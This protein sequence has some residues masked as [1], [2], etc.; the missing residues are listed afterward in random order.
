MDNSSEP[1]KI[2]LWG[3]LHDGELREIKTDAAN[4]TADLHV[5]VP[6]LSEF[7]G[8]PDD[9]GIRFHF[10]QVTELRVN[11]WV[12]DPARGN[13]DIRSRRW[14]RGEWKAL[15]QAIPP[16]ALDVLEASFSRLDGVG[17]RLEVAGYEL[18]ADGSS[19]DI[20]LEAILQGAGVT[21][22][23]P[24]GPSDLDRLLQIGD[25]YW[26]NVGKKRKR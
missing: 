2:S 7:F 8:W 19:T 15:E 14:A 17:G 9:S 23:T 10:D 18:E 26:D 12:P 11:Q 13:D 22:A 24:E 6:Y 5:V 16:K 3:V 25:A 20:W 4:Q 1:E 21:F